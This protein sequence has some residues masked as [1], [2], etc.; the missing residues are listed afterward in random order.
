[1]YERALA[2]QRSP[3]Y[4]MSIKLKQQK[5]EDE[6]ELRKFQYDFILMRT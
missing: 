4:L 6:K 2:K 1:V 5:K 3:E